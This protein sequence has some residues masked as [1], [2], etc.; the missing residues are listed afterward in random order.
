M[1]VTALIMAGGKG[2]RMRVATEKPLLKIGG[3]PMIE[4]VAR[5]LRES[6]TVDRIVVATSRNTL[7]TAREAGKLGLEVLQTPCDGYVSDLRYAISK[8]GVSDVLTV[9]ADLPFIT[10]ELVDRAVQEYRSCGKPALSVMAPMEVYKKL[11]SMPEHVFEIGGRSLV[12]IG[13]NVIDGKRIDEPELDQAVLVTGSEQ[14][15]T[16]VNTLEELEAARECFAKIRD[17]GSAETALAK[18]TPRAYRLARISMLSALSVI[19]SFIH[20]PTPISSVAF[21]SSPGFF[22][23]LY[24]GAQDGAIVSGIGHII[25]SVINGFPLGVLHLP[26]AF[27][28][29]V[30]G[31]MMGLVNHVNKRWGYAAAVP[32]GIAINSGLA[33]VLVPTF[34][35]G[36]ALGVLPFLFAAASLNGLVATFA[37]VGVR[38]RLKI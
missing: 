9:A 18:T 30:A 15:A 6:K 29:A 1:A 2:T 37:Y 17:T 31:G 13:L 11:G 27:G 20:P 5:A 14:Y 19:G 36:A 32:V 35:L 7:H 26:I 28:M 33:V 22:A 21:D 24:F 38:G 10:S 8:L 12:P 23:A 3:R 25:T 34:G 4:Q 16:N